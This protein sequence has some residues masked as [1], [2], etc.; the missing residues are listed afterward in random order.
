MQS[1]EAPVTTLSAEPPRPPAHAATSQVVA[2][3]VSMLQRY[4]DSALGC[5]A[6]PQWNE[7]LLS[8]FLATGT[9]DFTHARTHA[10]THV[11]SRQGRVL[12]PPATH[13]LPPLSPSACGRW[14]HRFVAGGW[15]RAE[16][17]GGV[18]RIGA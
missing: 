10:R 6:P 17:G 12:L 14:F 3:R 9:V 11:R 16:F 7:T 8:F 2:A 5:M 15:G 4:F 1:Q 13:C 18:R